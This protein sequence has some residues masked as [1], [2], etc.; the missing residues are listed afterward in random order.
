MP[1]FFDVL[2]S[3]IIGKIYPGGSELCLM[4]NSY[5]IK[6]FYINDTFNIKIIIKKKNMK[7]KSLNLLLS[8]TNQNNEKIYKNN[9]LLNL[10]L[11]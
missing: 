3:K 2:L 5:Y 6:P 10:K 7:L 1:F 9:L 11:I 8:V 4:S